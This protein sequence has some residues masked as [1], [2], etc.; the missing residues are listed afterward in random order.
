MSL[1]IC[2][3]SEAE[4]PAVS[5]VHL[6][7][8][9]ENLLTHAQFPSPEGLQFFHSWL[10]RNT[11]EHLRD[12]DKGVLVAKDGETGEVVSFVKWLV[13]RPG[14]GEQQ[15]QVEEEWPD[16]ARGEYLDPYAA[17][18]E[19]VR[20]RAVGEE[21]AYYHPTYL[22]TDPRWAGRG[23]ASLLLRK[24]QDL[25]AADGLPLVL[26]ATM[27]AVTF[28][29]KMGFEIKDELSMMLPPRGSSEPTEFYEE[30][31]MVWVPPKGAVAAS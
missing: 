23:A 10:E 16:V 13:H 3:P 2:A 21:A 31:C 26:E 11:L 5:T 15:H 7:A 1:I 20:N 9:D 18:T 24:V 4:A 14:E 28:Y 30:K 27:N 8:M 22:C 12:G 25:A 19:R 17:L 6:R 29:Q